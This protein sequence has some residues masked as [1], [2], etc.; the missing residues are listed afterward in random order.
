MLYGYRVTDREEVGLYS[1]DLIQI[2]FYHGWGMG[3]AELEDV[4]SSCRDKRIRY[5]IHPVNFFLSETR[6]REREATMEALR[7]MARWTDMG[8]IIHDEGTPLGG[9]LH[10]L[11]EKNYRD[12]LE[13]L[14]G[15]C[16]VSI[17][18]ANNSRDVEW[19]WRNYALS[20]TIDIG[21]LEA[22]GI[23]SEKWMKDLPSDLLDRVEYVHLHR[24]NGLRGG[25]T[26][27]WPIT[28]N[29][30]EVKAIEC[31]LKRKSD[32]NVILEINETEELEENLGILDGLR[33]RY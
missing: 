22:S 11:W 14:E 30:R 10:G 6:P 7:L 32:I 13:E 27:H 25:L 9:R 16:H 24:N 28:K 2:S 31:L 17:E 15:L 26:D 19:L 18:N 21:H 4:V 33:S 3:L 1:A 23:N 29:C 5:V 12:G 8:L 20:I